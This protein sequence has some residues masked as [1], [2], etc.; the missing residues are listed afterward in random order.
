[1]NSSAGE[2]SEKSLPC[3]SACG[4]DGLVSTHVVI[5]NGSPRNGNTARVLHDIEE[6]LRAEG[7]GTSLV[8]LA[9]LTIRDCTGCER[10]IRETTA[11]VFQDD[12]REILSQVLTADGL[13]LATPVYVGTV[14]GKLKSLIDKTAAWLHRPQ[15]VGL[16][17]L[18]VVTTAGSGRKRTLAYL[19]E[20]VT[21]WGAHPM[22]GISRTATD[23]APVRRGELDSFLR[24]LRIPKSRYRP[25][26]RQVVLF[27]VQK[28]LALKVA[29][30]DRLFWEE[31]GWDR[32][33]FYYSCRLS[34]GKRIVGR[35]VFALLMRRLKPAHTY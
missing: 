33:D 12:A 11:C 16:P 15:T 31:R 18:P 35:L 26:L 2:G 32:R 1:M 6:I 13:V 20:A 7:I 23:R 17:V 29:R 3:M 21:Y 4:T 25:S 28:V 22:A 8:H 9:G 24:H 34:L 14:T 5:I 19:T 27:N 10:C 30:I